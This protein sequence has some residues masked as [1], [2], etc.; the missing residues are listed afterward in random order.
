MKGQMG[1]GGIIP[2][3]PIKFLIF[4][5]CCN[6]ILGMPVRQESQTLWPWGFL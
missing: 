5:P 2:Q 3:A 6:V 4:G 1:W